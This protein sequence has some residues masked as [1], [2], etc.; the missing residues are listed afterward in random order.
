MVASTIH[1]LCTA[2]ALTA[3]GA[4]LQLPLFGASEPQIPV[5]GK[6]LISSS[7]LQSQIDVGKLLNRAKHLYSIAELGSDEY[8]RPT[9]VIGSKGSFGAVWRHVSQGRLTHVTS[10]HLGTLD[11]I[12]ATLTEFDDYYTISNQTFPAVTGNVME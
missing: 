9:R 7:A 4:A 6:E 2:F 3:E 12:Y 11:Y 10:G 1:L 5:A 8:N